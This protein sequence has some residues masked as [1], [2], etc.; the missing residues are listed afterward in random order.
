LKLKDRDFLKQLSRYIQFRGIDIVLHL[1]DGKTVEL[2]RNRR[3]DGRM[4]IY[5]NR[6]GAQDLIPLDD[7][8]RAEFFAP[9][10]SFSWLL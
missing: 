1:N 7:V 3:M 4:I 6:A 10:Q 9:N 5:H 8:K 2:D